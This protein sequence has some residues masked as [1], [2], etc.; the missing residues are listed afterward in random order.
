[1]IYIKLFFFLIY[2]IHINTPVYLLICLFRP[3]LHTRTY[4]SLLFDHFI[5]FFSIYLRNN[6]VNYFNSNNKQVTHQLQTETFQLLPKFEHFHPWNFFS[7]PKTKT[8][9]AI[10]FKLWYFTLRG[11]N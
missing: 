11:W 4:R 6:Y 3:L 2:I 5:K 7:Y 10:E 1:M 8:S 9:Q